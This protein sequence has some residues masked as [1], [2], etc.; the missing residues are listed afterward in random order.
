MYEYV[1]VHHRHLVISTGSGLRLELAVGAAGSGLCGGAAPAKR[2]GTGAVIHSD[3]TRLLPHALDHCILIIITHHAARGFSGFD[4]RGA[5]Q[6]KSNSTF[7]SYTLR[8]PP[9]HIVFQLQP[10]RSDTM[11]TRTPVNL[12]AHATRR[13]RHRASL[14]RAATAPTASCSY[15]GAARHASTSA[16]S[17]TSKN[18]WRGIAAGALGVTFVSPTTGSP[19]LERAADE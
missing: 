14:L 11:T 5:G 4:F 17:Q 10:T 1:R 2:A 8:S 3:S 18:E 9:R 13:A 6:Y 16:A 7:L 19:G 15:R 12:V